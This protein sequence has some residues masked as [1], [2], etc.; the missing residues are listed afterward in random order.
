PAPRRP[1][2]D[3]AVP[4]AVSAPPAP[5]A[6]TAEALADLLPAD[7]WQVHHAASTVPGI[8]GTSLLV[9]HHVGT[10]SQA[11]SL[12]NRLGTLLARPDGDGPV[13]VA[14][15]PLAPTVRGAMPAWRAEGRVV[16]DACRSTPDVVVAGDLNATLDHPA[17]R[18][19]APCVDAARA[20]GE[21]A[22]GTWPAAAPTLLS[23]PIDH[24][25][26]DGRA[27]RVVDAEVLP[28]VGASDHR[29]LVAVLARR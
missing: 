12:D 4:A 17:L 21:A 16:A 13:L 3:P 18:D 28:A 8:A 10:Y 15:H 19:T 27:W 29:P 20:A 24:V 14:A 5:P 25:L 2:R 9:A 1:T 23:A 11:Q 26:V 6:P 7:G 22:Q